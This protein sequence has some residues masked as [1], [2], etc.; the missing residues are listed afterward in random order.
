MGGNGESWGKWGK[1]GEIQGNWW[2]KM[3]KIFSCPPKWQNFCKHGIPHF[4]PLPPFFLGHVAL[5]TPPNPPPGPIKMVLGAFHAMLSPFFNK[6]SDNSHSRTYFPPFS[7][8]FPQFSP[9][10]PTF[11]RFSSCM[12][13]NTPPQPPERP[14]K[15]GFSG[16]SRNVV[17]IFPQYIGEPSQQDPFSPIFPTRGYFGGI[18]CSFP[19]AGNQG[20]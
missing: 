4:S 8:I 16:F 7:I 19:E 11:S 10:S 12:L 15:S 17:P 6:T 2:R 3:V 13:L 20:P 5:Y 1:M 18:T 9:F 14:T